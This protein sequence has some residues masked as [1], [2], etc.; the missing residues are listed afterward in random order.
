MIFDV[1]LIYLDE[2]I[3]TSKAGNT[4][5]VFKFLDDTDTVTCMA[6]DINLHC[7]LD[8]FDSCTCK[9]SLKINQYTNLRLL[10]IKNE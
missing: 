8:K 1:D 5:K 6:E 9:F 3:K 4:Y 7:N 10:D 2:E